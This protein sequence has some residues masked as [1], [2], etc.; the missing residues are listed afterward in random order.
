MLLLI[1]GVALY[2]ELH[3]PGVGIGGFV[4][5]VCF[6]LF[7]WSHY[8]G[9][10]AGWL[11]IILFLTGI[12]CLLLEV[13]VLPGFGIFG[14]G[15]RHWSWPRWSWPARPSCCRTTNIEFDQLERSL[16]SI[17]VARR[18][19]SLPYRGFRA[20]GCRGALLRHMVLASARG[21]R[22]PDHQSPRDA[23]GPGDCLGVEGVTTTQLTPGG[24]ARFGNALID[25]IGAGDVVLATRR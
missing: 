6:L 2:I 10:T 12:A 11:E 3:A 9:S 13:F 16:L 22:G 5:A 8:L 25:V 19:V 1:G 14:L 18:G 7:F 4:A 21:R 24:K 23:G 17:A 20:V 15:G